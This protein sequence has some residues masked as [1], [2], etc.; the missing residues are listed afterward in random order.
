ML[1]GREPDNA[2]TCAAPISENLA[3]G[4]KLSIEGTPGIV[5]ASGRLVPGAIKRELIERYLAEP[6]P[7]G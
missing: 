1:K 2:G 5:F 7:A 4:E 6:R 3:L